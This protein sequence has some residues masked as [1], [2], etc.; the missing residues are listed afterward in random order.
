MMNK[1]MD[2]YM[3]TDLE[4]DSRVDSSLRL[5]EQA[6]EL[7]PENFSALIHR[8]TLCYERR[9]LE[10]LL[11][12]ADALMAYSPDPMFIG[13]KA[14]YLELKGDSAS[15][16]RSYDLALRGYEKLFNEDSS[17]FG[18]RLNYIGLLHLVGDTLAAK[19]HLARVAR[20]DLND[21]EREALTMLD[22]TESTKEVVLNEWKAPRQ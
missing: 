14:V 22:L 6:L 7:D 2:V 18:F 5:T 19:D 12:N 11:R 15:A 17:D 9:D 8:G 13:Q 1:A 16:K 21:M 10:G 4:Q 20:M 3:S